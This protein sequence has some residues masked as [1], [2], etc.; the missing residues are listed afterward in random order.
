MAAVAEP[1]TAY[2]RPTDGHGRRVHGRLRGRTGSGTTLAWGNGRDGA[3][4]GTAAAGNPG[5]TALAVQ[6]QPPSLAIGPASVINDPTVLTK[7][8]DIL[9]M[10]HRRRNLRS[11]PMM[12]RSSNEPAISSQ[13]ISGT[14]R[15]LTR[16]YR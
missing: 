16:E 7:H 3:R 4:V 2:G 13:A 11:A 8:R 10:V 1:S 6:G 14:I 5:R 15:D 9:D 12:M